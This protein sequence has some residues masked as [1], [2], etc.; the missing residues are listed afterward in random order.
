MSDLLKRVKESFGNLYQ[1]D[2][3]IVDY[4][5]GEFLQAGTIP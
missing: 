1:D 2:E 4:F 5:D 3:E